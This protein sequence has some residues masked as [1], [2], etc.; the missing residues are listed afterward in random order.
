MPTRKLT[1]CYTE[2]L[3]DDRVLEGMGQGRY[4]G[5][6]ARGLLQTLAQEACGPRLL[7]AAAS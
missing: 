3:A 2:M 1:A 6:P 4:G 7:E 5:V